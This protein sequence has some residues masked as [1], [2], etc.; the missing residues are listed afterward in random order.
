MTPRRP[1]IR[2]LRQDLPGEIWGVAA[3]FGPVGTSTFLHNLA[4]FS[5]NVR[6]QGLRLLVVELA[7]DRAPFHIGNHIADLVVR[8]RASDLM[9]QKERLIN[10]GVAS[11]PKQCD[12]VVWLDTDILFENAD[13]VAETADNLEH[14]P[15]LQ[16]FESVYWLPRGETSPVAQPPTGMGDGCIM[17]GMAY[18]MTG[19]PDRRR[20]LADF[21]VHGHTGFAWAARR[22]LLVH[23]GLYDRHILGGGDVSIA[24]SVFGDRDYWRG[25]NFFCRNMTK[26]EQVAVAAWGAAFHADVGEEVSF[27]PGRLL[28]LWHGALAQR[29]YVSRGQILKEHQF[30]PAIDV[31]IDGSGCLRWNSNKP[32]L[33]AAVR[34]YFASRVLGAAALVDA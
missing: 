27:V 14:V 3:C 30:D 18:A 1:R 15:V 12:K 13:W 17:A 31:A 16:P 23:H 10:L 9:W 28:H 21:F 7:A 4:R 24:H 29:R 22:S 20:A 6:A 26:P 32:G 25:R 5:E 33:H 2:P 19:V 34:A 11:L 8:L